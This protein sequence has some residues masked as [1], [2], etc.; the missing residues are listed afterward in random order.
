MAG[1]NEAAKRA[2]DR[3]YAI[4]KAK[5]DRKIAINQRNQALFNIATST[6]MGIVSA[7]TLT[8]ANPVLS[9]IL[10]A[11]I[12]SLGAIQAAAVSNKEL[13]KI[14][15]YDSGTGSLPSGL[16]EIAEKRPE[17][18]FPKHGKPFLQKEKISY[19]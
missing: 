13:P 16:V 3:K 9:G 1:D 19:R 8:P 15:S 10:T 12:T 17:I 4:E 5:I 14:P 2:A 18:V 11:F 7:W 6:A